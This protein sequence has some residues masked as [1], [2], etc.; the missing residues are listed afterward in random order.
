MSKYTWLIDSG[1]GGMDA[2]GKYITAPA[3]MFR[4]SPTEVFYEGVFNREIKSA[5]IRSLWNENI[6]A[7]DVCPTELDLPLET[8]VNIINTLYEKYRNA[9]LISLHSN[10]GG[11]TGFEVWTS[12]GQ[13]RSDRFATGLWERFSGDFPG[14]RMRKDMADDDVDKEAA[15]YIL[16][17]TRCPAILPECLFYDNY[18]DFKKLENPMFKD[19]YVDT[20][21]SFILE[22]ETKNW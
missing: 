12:Y 22:A 17:W 4:H 14:I 7:I 13:T 18:D 16:K 1:H 2:D 3:K 10:A 8:R 19:K 9:V 20:L 21:K 11:G 6:L 15:F 5:L